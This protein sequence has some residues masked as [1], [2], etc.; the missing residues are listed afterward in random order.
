[1]A[2]QCHWDVNIIQS[3]RHSGVRRVVHTST[4]D[5]IGFNPNGLADETWTDFNFGRFG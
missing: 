5:T 1:M 3:A 4:V 2:H